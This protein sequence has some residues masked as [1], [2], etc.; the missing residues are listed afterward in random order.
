MAEA[1]PQERQGRIGQ[2]RKSQD[3]KS[4][5]RKRQDDTL[6][7]SAFYFFAQL[8]ARGLNFLYFLILARS[9]PTD[10]FGV[11]SYA[12]TVVVVIDIVIDLG[13]SRHAMRQMSRDAGITGRMLSMILPAKMILAALA[14]GALLIWLSRSGM[15]RDYRL[16]F[17]VASASL[18]LTAPAMM[19]E[20]VLQAHGRFPRI[21][22]AHLALAVVQFAVGGAIVLLGGP[23]FIV[24]ATFA[25]T[26]AVYS[27]ILISGILALRPRPR[28]RPRLGGLF[29]ELPP[30]LP[31]LVSSLI[32]LLAIRAEFLILG[33]FG[34]PEELGVF[35]IA[36][37][38]IEAALLLPMALATVLAPRF[39][40]A[41]VRAR[42]D[43]RRLYHAGL[44]LVLLATIP[45]AV[46]AWALAPVMSVVLPGETFAQAGAVLRILFIGFPAAGVFLYNVALLSGATY[47]RWP[48]ALLS[49]LSAVQLGLN[50]ALQSRYGIWGAAW[51]FM[52]FMPLA[53]LVT[54][55]F[56]LQRYVGVRRLWHVVVPP[57]TGFLA[58]SPLILLRP[59]MADWLLVLPG[60]GLFG[61]FAL[62]AR[63]HLPGGANPLGFH[64]QP[65][66]GVSP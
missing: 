38:I 54:T 55:A 57:L 31:F 29:R 7:H 63:A 14:W 22:L 61:L 3:R 50:L 9:L 13:L 65:G 44:E 4:Q 43:L 23:T 26:Y 59:F 40:G 58:M 21:S 18:M 30:A 46:L 11:L 16:I 8:A 24:A 60:L 64:D 32:V 10:E 51:S 33:M 12:L 56:V 25:A 27:L 34:S 36:T 47:Q 62:T 19:L 42:A 49:L 35:G 5:D 39:A 15:E 20:N 2:G 66:P 6:A 37:K 17:T 52:L 45:A 53:A 28:L 41:H 48:L 1:P